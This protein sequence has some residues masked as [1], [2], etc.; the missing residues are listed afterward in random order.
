MTFVEH[1]LAYS[2]SDN[3]RDAVRLL[4]RIRYDGGHIS[5][6]TRNHYTEADWN[7]H[8]D[9]LLED[10]TQ[11]VGGDAVRQYPLKID[12]AKFFRDRYQL[13]TDLPDR[14][15]AGGLH[16]TGRYGERRNR[17]CGMATSSILSTDRAT[18]AG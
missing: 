9:W 16:S 3:L 5:V 11:V 1:I 13:D 15:I 4:Q 7:V 6:L 8:N 18:P 2:L 17:S 12:R 14:G 10:I